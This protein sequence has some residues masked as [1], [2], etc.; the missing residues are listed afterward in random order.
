LRATRRVRLI[1]LMSSRLPERQ[2]WPM[3]WIVLAIVVGIGL[4]TF[5]TLHYRKPGRAY[6]PYEDLK[7]RFN[8]ERLLAAGYRRIEL[9]AE[10]PIDLV[11]D[12]N[13]AM[14]A[15]GGLPP[16]LKATVISNPRLPAEILEARAAASASAAE[17]YRIALRCTVPDDH[18]QLAGA[19]MYLKGDRIVVTPDY[20]LLTGGLLS[21]S[22]DNIVLLTVPAGALK[23]GTYQVTLIGERVSRAWSVTLR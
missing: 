2:P 11:A 4:Y 18:R 22:R 13:A 5:L 9:V 6:R 7:T 23:P 20:E 14:P 21:R 15:P 19:E 8:T 16:D 12:Q 17:P 10:S 3:K 1:G